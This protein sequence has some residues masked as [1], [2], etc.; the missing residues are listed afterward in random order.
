[1][2]GGSKPELILLHKVQQIGSFVL[3]ERQL[4]GQQLDEGQLGGQQLGVRQLEGRQLDGGQL[5]VRQLGGEQ[6]G[7]KPEFELVEFGNSLHLG[8][9]HFVLQ[10]NNFGRIVE[11]V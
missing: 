6:Q 4:G 9:S 3:A 5:G 2:H 10:P 1:M 8:S 7:S 11:I